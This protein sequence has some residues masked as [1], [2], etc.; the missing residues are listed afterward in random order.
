MTIFLIGDAKEHWLTV[1]FVEYLYSLPNGAEPNALLRR[2]LTH[3]SATIVD[4][5]YVYAVSCPIYRYD[6]MRLAHVFYGMKAMPESVFNKNLDGHSRQHY[7]FYL[8]PYV[9]IYL[10]FI[11]QTAAHFPSFNLY[12]VV[13]KVQFVIKCSAFFFQ[14]GQGRGV[15]VK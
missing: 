10:L 11:Y 1:A 6:E 12:V 8:P 3:H 14:L 15:V 5:V 4:D 7:L 2:R 13:N 9:F